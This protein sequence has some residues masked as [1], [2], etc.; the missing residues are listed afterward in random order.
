MNLV[1]EIFLKRPNCVLKIYLRRNLSF[2][3]KRNH[4]RK[5]IFFE[6]GL[7]KHLK[8][9]LLQKNYLV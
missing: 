5:D 9:L 8:S 4:I 2:L 7:K 3:K 6:L 1:H